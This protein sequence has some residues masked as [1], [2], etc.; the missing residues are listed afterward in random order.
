MSLQADT[1]VWACAMDGSTGGKGEEEGGPDPS[2]KSQKYRV[3]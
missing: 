3:Y 1:E 2:E